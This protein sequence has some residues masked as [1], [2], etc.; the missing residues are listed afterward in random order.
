MVK[1][2]DK[3]IFRI[4]FKVLLET[5]WHIKDTT[6][7]TY[8]Y[9]SHVCVYYTI[10]FRYIFFNK[11][12]E[13]SKSETQHNG[14]SINIHSDISHLPLCIFSQRSIFHQRVKIHECCRETIAADYWYQDSRNDYSVYRTCWLATSRLIKSI[15][16]TEWAFSRRK[17]EKWRKR[18]KK[19]LSR[20]RRSTKVGVSSS[21]SSSERRAEKE[22]KK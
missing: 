2:K 5:Y 9:H 8:L 12:N 3:L 4:I 19:I 16:I 6:V 14:F 15:F 20:A 13:K 21:S 1:E 11:R 7:I 17:K 10:F 18:K 22:F